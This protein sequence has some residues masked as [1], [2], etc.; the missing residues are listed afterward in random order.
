[1]G[2]TDRD[3]HGA[4]RVR[5]LV[6]VRVRHLQVARVRYR[7]GLNGCPSCVPSGRM[8]RIGGGSN[9][10]RPD[11]EQQRDRP[12]ASSSASRRCR[13]ALSGSAPAPDAPHLRVGD[14]CPIKIGASVCSAL[15]VSTGWD[16][17]AESRSRSSTAHTA[18]RAPERDAS[19]QERRP[20]CDTRAAAGWVERRRS[21]SR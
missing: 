3:V 14:L 5:R 7:T 15:T 11:G 2:A 20:A 19:R 10:Q 13:S 18:A 6:G 4:R 21:W 12:S 1:V 8:R 16:A 9:A 17:H